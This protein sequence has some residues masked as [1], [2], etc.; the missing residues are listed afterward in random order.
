LFQNG[1]LI[2]ENAPG[3]KITPSLFIK[4]DRIQ[5]GLSLAV[6]TIETSKDGGTMHA[7]NAAK[8]EHRLIYVPDYTKSGYQDKSIE[9]ISGIIS[10]Y[11]DPEVEAYTK[12]S[13]PQIIERLNIKEND[14]FSVDKAQ[15]TLL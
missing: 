4:R 9:Q 7:V 3:I 5:A 14:I 2:S 6:F 1:L 10:L 11:S 12:A 8:Q 13:Y 15:G